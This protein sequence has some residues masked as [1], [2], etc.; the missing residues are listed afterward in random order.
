MGLAKKLLGKNEL[1]SAL[2]ALAMLCI[3]VFFNP[4]FFAHANLESLQTSIAPY[5]IMASGMMIL[6]ITGVFDLSVGSNMCL[7]G[8]VTAICLTNSLGVAAAMAAGLLAGGCVGLVNGLLI[9]R[10]RINPLIVTIGTM[11][12]ARG[13]CE[14]VLVGRGKA[15]YSGFPQFFL[16]LGGGKWFG[17]Y[18][19]FWLMLILMACIQFYLLRFPGGRRLYFIGGNEDAAKLLNINKSRLRISAFVLSGI[20]SALAGILVTAR[21]GQANRY[22]GQG[23]HM[24][25]II[26]CIIG[27]ASLSGGKGSMPGALFGLLFISLLSNAFNLFSVQ[28]QYQNIAIGAILVIVVVMDGYIS[29]KKQKAKGQG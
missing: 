28:P 1:V 6:L 7:G 4:Y 12:I 10:A 16:D 14:M 17:L 13:V 2:L 24:D 20:L 21:A 11:Y 15:G 29:L 5:G 8:L 27:G 25:I 3:L 9:E 19:M 23:A 18:P 22:T 26:I